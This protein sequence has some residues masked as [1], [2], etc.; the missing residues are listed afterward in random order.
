MH[1]F[2]TLIMLTVNVKNVNYDLVKQEKLTTFRPIL[3]ISMQVR[4]SILILKMPIK[5]IFLCAC[6]SFK[7]QGS[8][9]KEQ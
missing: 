6:K 5:K 1:T 4:F 2:K 9:L 7:R 8:S 3:A